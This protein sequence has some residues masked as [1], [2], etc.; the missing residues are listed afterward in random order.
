M[1]L[2][3]TRSSGASK[4]CRRR[5]TSKNDLS[6]RSLSSSSS[7]SA[8]L[9]AREKRERDEANRSFIPSNGKALASTR[10][11]LYQKH[12]ESASWSENHLQTKDI[13]YRFSADLNRISTSYSMESELASLVTGRS[14]SSSFPSRVLADCSLPTSSGV[15]TATAIQKRPAA[16]R[17]KSNTSLGSS[18]QS[19]RQGRLVPYQRQYQQISQNCFFFSTETE[20]EKTPIKAPSPRIGTTKVPTPASAP[21]QTNNFASLTA[22][23]KIVIQ[24][25][26]DGTISV[27]KTVFGF[28][29][30]L[31]GNVWFY[32]SHPTERKERI[33]GLQQLAKDE[34]H[35]Y[36]VGTKVSENDKKKI[37]DWIGSASPD[38]K[39]IPYTNNATAPLL[40]CPSYYSVTLGRHSDSTK[41]ARKDFG[42]KRIDPT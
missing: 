17:S 37:Y 42:W 22:S 6:L 27:F 35:H 26:L 33:A 2:L 31:P 7:A 28:F 8:S 16:W 4:L 39:K 32:I 30:R 38:S 9:R 19:L 40:T 11:N 3:L 5:Y 14:T 18:G 12:Q 1:L 29:I 21:V 13:F 25:I 10:M 41:V 34:L 36:W 20:K 24:K 15:S 23:P